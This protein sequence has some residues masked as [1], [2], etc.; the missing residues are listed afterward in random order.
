MRVLFVHANFPGQFRHMAE[1]LGR[2][3][4]N[5]VVFATQN[6]RPEWT[7]AGV[8]KA[9]AAKVPEEGEGHPLARRLTTAFQNGLEFAKLCRSL[10][11]QGFVPDVM[12]GHSGWGQTMFLRDVFPEAP[13]IGYFEWFYDAFGEDARFE[14]PISGDHRAE[15]RIKN[16]PILSDLSTCALGLTPTLWQAAQFPPDQRRKLAV[17]HDGV[18]TDY[19]T[20]AP[21]ST[22]KLPSLDLSGAAEIVTYAARG[23]EPYRGFPQFIEALALV[24]KERPGCHAV[25]LGEDRV[26]YGRPLPDGRT[27]KQEMLS[28]VGLDLSRVHFTGPLPYGQYKQVLQASSAHVYLT[29]PFVLS[30]SFLEAM[31]MGCLVVGSDTA[32][33]REVLRHGE[34]GLLTDFHSPERIAASLIEALEG[35]ERLRP[36]REQARADVVARYDLKKLLP[37]RLALVQRAARAKPK[38]RGRWRPPTMS[39]QGS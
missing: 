5:Q 4:G 10:R 32:P 26:C 29:R 39:G 18:D 22:L 37:I 15:L 9:V 6:E 8:R 3:P 36:L 13:F 23:M 30:W 16:L 24:Q 20:P 17:V 2:D 1:V 12:L 7:M 33:V 25:V 14:G 21:G 28:K 11:E 38:A 19:F 35:R 31:A 34:N 27:W